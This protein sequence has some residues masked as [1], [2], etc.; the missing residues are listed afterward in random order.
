MAN[1]RGVYPKISKIRTIGDK[2]FSFEQKC[3]VNADREKI[4]LVCLD[5]AQKSHHFRT[6]GKK[7]FSIKT[8]G[9]A[10]EECAHRS[11]QY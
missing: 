11:T 10:S 4:K 6:A 1:F 3:N 8:V 7:F 5:I 9:N 2:R